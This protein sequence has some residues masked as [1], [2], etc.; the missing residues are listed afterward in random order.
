MGYL[1]KLASKSGI[2]KHNLALY[3]VEY[4]WRYNYRHLTIK[5]QTNKI[6]TMLYKHKFNKI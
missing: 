1:K 3:F 5:Q 4:V 2:I 6:L